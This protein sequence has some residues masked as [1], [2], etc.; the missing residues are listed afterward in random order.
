[1]AL[2]YSPV[3][4]KRAGVTYHLVPTL[5]W[6]AHKS[7]PEYTPEAYEADGFIHC[8]DGL[9]QLLRV[10]N[11]FYTNDTRPFTVL[12]LAVSEITSPVRYD[13][14]DRLFPHIYGPLNTSAVRDELS[15][16]RA[17]D[18]TFVGFG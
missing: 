13:D 12:V 6:E 3:E 14:P 7:N 1:M 15:V 17:G 18:G 11:T 16:R 4:A 10:A 5:V 9:D 2:H 8:T